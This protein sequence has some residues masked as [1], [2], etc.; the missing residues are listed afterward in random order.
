MR[1][2]AGRSGRGASLRSQARTHPVTAVMIAL[3]TAKPSPVTLARIEAA[4]TPTLVA[5]MIGMAARYLLS[6]GAFG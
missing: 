4:L 1:G 6:S 2:G 3:E 5:Q